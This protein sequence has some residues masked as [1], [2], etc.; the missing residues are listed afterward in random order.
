MPRIVYQV[1]QALSR[2]VD[3]FIKFPT[4]A[5][6]ITEP[7]QGFYAIKNF[8]NVIGAIDCTQIEILAPH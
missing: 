2:K 4:N 5:Q 6:L 7:K 3:Q 8:P 1:S